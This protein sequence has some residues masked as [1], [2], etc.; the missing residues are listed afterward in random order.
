MLIKEQ[1]S[2]EHIDTVAFLCGWNVSQSLTFLKQKENHVW[3]APSLF[4]YIFYIIYI[5]FL[6]VSHV[7]DVQL[8]C[9]GSAKRQQTN[10]WDQETEVNFI[11][12]NYHLCVANGLTE[13]RKDTAGVC[14]VA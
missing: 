4:V 1:Q 8:A 14:F 7:H 6:N 3:L 5:L 2:E 13:N 11:G 12:I 9:Y 10:T